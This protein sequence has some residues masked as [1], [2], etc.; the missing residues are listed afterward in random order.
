V[1]AG[2][3]ATTGP[4]FKYMQLEKQTLPGIS[5]ID[6]T[7]DIRKEISAHAL[8]EGYVNVLS[9]HTTT[10][11]TINEAEPR[12]MD[13]IRQVGGSR[14]GTHEGKQT[15]CHVMGHYQYTQQVPSVYGNCI[16]G[17]QEGCT[18]QMASFATVISNM[19]AFLGQANSCTQPTVALSFPP[20]PC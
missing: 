16:Q 15:D 13:D 6:I 1:Q 8:R 14:H 17:M 7:P 11:V 20:V 2:S 18:I 4:I 10:A 12:L 3:A 5:L 9:R 19:F